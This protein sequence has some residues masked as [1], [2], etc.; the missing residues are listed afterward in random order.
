MAENIPPS[1]RNVQGKRMP[2]IRVCRVTSVT[3]RGASVATATSTGHSTWRLGEAPSIR[4]TGR[5][6]RVVCGWNALV[7]GALRQLLIHHAHRPTA[8]LGGRRQR[9]AK[10]AAFA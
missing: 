5:F 10:G 9:E 3:F 8:N 4:H 1:A 6:V 7:A 2:K